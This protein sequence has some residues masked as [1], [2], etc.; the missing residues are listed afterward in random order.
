MVPEEFTF[1]ETPFNLNVTFAAGETSKRIAVP[2]EDDYRDEEDG[3]VTLS[4]PAKADQYKYI[5]GHA[6][7]ATADVRDNDVLSRFPCTGFAPSTLTPTV[8][9]TLR[10][11]VAVYPWWCTD[12]PRANRCR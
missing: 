2:T 4:V 1:T 7:S 9:W 12:E 5:P 3:T 6:S 11:R 8:I 10:W